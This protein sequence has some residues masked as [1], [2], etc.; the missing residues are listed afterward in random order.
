MYEMELAL[1]FHTKATW[2]QSSKGDPKITSGQQ[3]GIAGNHNLKIANEHAC[4]E[5]SE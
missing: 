1:N 4:H 3:T 5:H 2:N